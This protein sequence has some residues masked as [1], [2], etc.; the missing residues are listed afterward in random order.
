MAENCPHC[1]ID[2]DNGDIVE[3]FQKMRE[4]GDPFWRDKTNI[5]IIKIAGNYGW[6]PETPKRFSRVIGVELP[7]DHPKHYDGV[8]YW[9]CPDCKQQWPRFKEKHGNS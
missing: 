1:G 8:S 5:E 7:Y 4:D 6:T 2:L 3:T 9:M